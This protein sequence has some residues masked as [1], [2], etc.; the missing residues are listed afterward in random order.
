MLHRLGLF[1]I[2]VFNHS[3]WLFSFQ[4]GDQHA[5][6]GGRNGKRECIS[7]FDVLHD[8]APESRH[9]RELPPKR[10]TILTDH[11][12]SQNIMT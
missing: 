11:S 3:T 8:L 4:L 12:G 9:M 7:Q 6:L 1:F 2:I 10:L 5:G